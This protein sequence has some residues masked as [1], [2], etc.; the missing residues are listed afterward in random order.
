[1]KSES[2]VCSSLGFPT[3]ALVWINEI[4]SAR[5]MD[6]FKSSSSIV[7]RRLPDFEVL[8]SKLASALRKL[9]TA[10]FK[11]LVY[12]EGQSRNRRIDS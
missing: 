10:D 5:I 9:L 11:R 2:D 4:D 8:D 3:E 1:M 6:E 7:E 12:M